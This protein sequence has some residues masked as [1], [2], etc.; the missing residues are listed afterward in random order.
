MTIAALLMVAAGS[1]ESSTGPLPGQGFEGKR[2]AVLEMGSTL[3]L[4]SL[5]NVTDEVRGELS[6]VMGPQGALILTREN[7]SEVTKF[8]GGVCRE[9]ECEVETGRNLNVHFVVSGTVTRVDGKLLLSL[10]LH[11]VATARLLG[12]E[13]VQGESELRLIELAP[14]AARSLVK[15]GLLV[16]SVVMAPVTAIAGRTVGSSTVAK[17]EEDT[18]IIEF[19]TAPPEASVTVDGTV[20]CNRTPCSRPVARGAH[21]VSFAR[22]EYDEVRLPVTV[23]LSSDRVRTEL[24]PSFGTLSVRR[25]PS[26]LPLLLDGVPFTELKAGERRR[27]PPG[28]HELVVNSPCHVLAA[29]RFTLAKGQHRDVELE[30]QPR[31]ALLRVLTH[32][33]KDNAVKGDVWADGV[34]LGSTWNSV[35]VP[36][37]SQ[38]LEVRTVYGEDFELKLRLTE[39]EAKTFSVLVPDLLADPMP[40]VPPEQR[41]ELRRRAWERRTAPARSRAWH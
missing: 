35:R 22:E 29:E 8:S 24:P 11:E 12:Q 14:P 5:S 2:I 32:D 40:D 6:R 4:D 34:R 27:L 37:C 28:S 17:I 3:E 31:T 18:V 20:I 38:R 7:I 1:T 25:S 41:P 15:R 33:P 23:S 30:G 16:T 21:L 39:G 13:L 9:G 19:E 36:I 10:K 26:E